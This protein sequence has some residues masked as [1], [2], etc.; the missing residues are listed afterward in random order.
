M[1]FKQSS[2][3][4][5]SIGKFLNILLLLQQLK[6]TLDCN[7]PVQS[8]SKE[9]WALY[10]FFSISV[11]FIFFFNTLLLNVKEIK[12][13]LRVYA[14]C[15]LVVFFHS[16]LPRFSSLWHQKVRY[17][18]FLCLVVLQFYFLKFMNNFVLKSVSQGISGD[19][20]SSNLMAITFS[21]YSSFSCNIF[22]R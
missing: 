14:E 21:R 3:A 1:D 7:G 19:S 15:F 2:K 8:C 5:K 12:A 13:F 17:P 6:S 9:R 20:S 16:S 10:E 11:Q 4:K 18:M 22:S